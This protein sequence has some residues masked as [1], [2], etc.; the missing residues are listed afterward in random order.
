M[1]KGVVDLDS[2][3]I[4]L[5]AQMHADLEQILLNQGSR[6][7]ALWGFNL[8]PEKDGPAFIEFTS[9]INIRPAQGNASIEVQEP[10]IR[11]QILEVIQKWIVDA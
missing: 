8:Y 5:E 9:L 4:A 7:Q 2:G 10:A 1:T 3:L 6:Q 11:K